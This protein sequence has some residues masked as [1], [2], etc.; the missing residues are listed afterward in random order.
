MLRHTW[1]VNATPHGRGPSYRGAS[2]RERER[3][4]R[5]VITR[6]VTMVGSGR[7]SCEWATDMRK[8]RPC[9]CGYTPP[10]NKPGFGIWRGGRRGGPYIRRHTW[11]CMWDI[12]EPECRVFF[13]HRPLASPLCLSAL[14]LW[15]TAHALFPSLPS[16]RNLNKLLCSPPNQTLDP[17]S[18][19]L[20]HFSE[21]IASHCVYSYHNFLSFHLI[22]QKYFQQTF[23]PIWLLC[24]LP[25]SIHFSLLRCH[26]IKK[27]YEGKFLRTRWSGFTH[28]FW[29]VVVIEFCQLHWLLLLRDK[30]NC[31]T[32]LLP[33][34]SKDGRKKS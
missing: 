5:A 2:H 7:Q 19:F 27:R 12:G 13:F 17:E 34:L 32:S 23:F 3:Y 24:L 18:R 25:L 8:S 33:F 11:Q 6:P 14:V 15:G 16:R 26:E 22:S 31:R 21:V 10:I 28:T 9:F 20:P 30:R 29:K 1:S 4:R